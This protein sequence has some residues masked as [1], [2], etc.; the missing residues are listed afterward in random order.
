MFSYLLQSFFEWTYMHTYLYIYIYLYTFVWLELSKYS[1]LHSNLIAFGKVS[2]PFAG[3]APATVVE[4]TSFRATNTKGLEAVLH[5]LL[6]RIDASADA[7]PTSPTA[8]KRSS[9]G[10]WA[11]WLVCQLGLQ[12]EWL[13]NLSTCAPQ[14]ARSASSRACGLSTTRRRPRASARLR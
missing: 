1:S 9:S 5:F 3:F 12:I 4:P 6:T 14:R 13:A 11:C 2:P 10:C 8:L 7:E